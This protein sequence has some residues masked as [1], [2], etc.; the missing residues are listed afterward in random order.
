L[1]L[2]LNACYFAQNEPSSYSKCSTIASSALFHLF[3]NSN[4]VSF[5]EGGRKNISCPRAQ[6]TLATPLAPEAPFSDPCNLTHTNCT[7]KERSNF[8]AH[9]KSILMSKIWGDFRVLSLFVILPLYFTWS[10]DG[11]DR[12][13]SRGKKNRCFWG[14]KLLILPKA[15]QF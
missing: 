2:V 3:F 8:V 14:C 1:F 9:K 15:I 10:G 11:T 5:V 12:I 7:A 4:F 6:G 13:H